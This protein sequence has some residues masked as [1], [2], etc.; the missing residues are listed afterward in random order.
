MIN[1]YFIFS[2]CFVLLCKENM[3][4]NLFAKCV[5]TKIEY[6]FKKYNKH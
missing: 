6:Y 4:I 5:I 3:I 1:F 2:I